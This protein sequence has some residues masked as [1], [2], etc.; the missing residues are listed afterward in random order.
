V[1]LKDARIVGDATRLFTQKATRTHQPRR[2]TEG[3]SRRITF[4]SMDV[5]IERRVATE[6]VAM[7]EA[8]SERRASPSMPMIDP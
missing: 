8:A 3:K 2:Y 4:N 6:A 5:D 7:V 1:S